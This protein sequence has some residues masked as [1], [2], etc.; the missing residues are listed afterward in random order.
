MDLADGIAYG[1]H[2][3]EDGIALGR[4]TEAHIAALDAGLLNRGFE[5]HQMEPRHPVESAVH[6]VPAHADT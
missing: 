3:L 6:E 2:D 1:V 5:S 4:I